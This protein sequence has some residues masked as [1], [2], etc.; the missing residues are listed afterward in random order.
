MPAYANTTAFFPRRHSRT[1]GIDA[2]SDFVTWYARKLQA[3]P[4]PFLYQLIAVADPAGCHLYPHL[5][6]TRLRNIAFDQ[7]KITAW[8]ANLGC[9][10]FRFHEECRAFSY[11]RFETTTE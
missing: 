8:F 4:E 9:C 10:H 6:G 5:P 7:L 2:A 1:E 3:G 11:L